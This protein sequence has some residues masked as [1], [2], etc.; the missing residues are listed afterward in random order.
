MCGWLG[1]GS[2]VGLGPLTKI[3]CLG[4]YILIKLI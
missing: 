2:D 4:G 1:L 3:H